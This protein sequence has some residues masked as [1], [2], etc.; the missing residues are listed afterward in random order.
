VTAI[1]AN[2]GFYYK[3]HLVKAIGDNKVVKAEYTKKNSAGID[4][5]YFDPVI[6]GMSRVVNA[7]GGTA[8]NAKIND[9]EICGKTGT[10]QNPHGDDHSVFIAFAPRINP[11]IA[12]AVVVENAGYGSTWSAPIASLMIEKYLRDSIS[13]PKYYTDRL[14]NANLLP[15]QKKLYLRPSK[16]PDTTKSNRKIIQPAVIPTNKRSL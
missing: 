14:V 9:I 15:G 2:R 5:K 12:I 3:P 7:P 11:K 1:L 6:E 10:V 4:A 16:K 13:R 8:Y